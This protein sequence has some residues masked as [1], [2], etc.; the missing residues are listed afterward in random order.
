[1]YRFSDVVIRAGKLLRPA[2][3]LAWQVGDHQSWATP[4][5]TPVTLLVMLT[6]QSYELLS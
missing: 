6:C 1:M 5:V 2:T 3:H 4:A